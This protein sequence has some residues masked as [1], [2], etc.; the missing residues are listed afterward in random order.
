MKGW[1]KS[2]ALQ[3]PMDRPTD[4]TQFIGKSALR[5]CNWDMIIPW[6]VAWMHA[7]CSRGVQGVAV[8]PVPLCHLQKTLRLCSNV[9]EALLRSIMGSS[10]LFHVYP[11]A[12][13]YS[14]SLLFPR[15]YV[16][17]CMDSLMFR[18]W[19]RLEAILKQHVAYKQKPSIY[20][21][22]SKHLY[23]MSL[24]RDASRYSESAQPFD[25]V[26]EMVLVPSFLPR[27]NILQPWPVT[28]SGS[29]FSSLTEWWH[30]DS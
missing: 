10:C 25:C 3:F 21:D 27:V 29:H 2:Q 30:L 6:C 9:K 19:C 11:E 24:Q 20:I 8:A 13:L 7:V 16:A 26:W 23:F 14:F 22:G 28:W 1:A 4:K 17:L 5:F 15:L 18:D 12:V